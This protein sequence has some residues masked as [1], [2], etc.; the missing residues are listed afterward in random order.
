MTDGESFESMLAAVRSLS[1]DEIADAIETIGFACTDCGAC[2]RGDDTEEHT[3]TIFPDEIRHIAERT[4]TAWRD[5]ARPMPYG[6]D[7]DGTGET[8][9]WA[10]ATDECGDCRFL[11]A[12]E[13]G[14]SRCG[15]YQDRPLICR[16]YPFTLAASP[17]GEPL[18]E[19]VAREGPLV[20]HE[21]EGLGESIGRDDAE[22][23]ARALKRRGERAAREAI[24]VRDALAE[25]H[26]AA[27]TVVVDSEGAKMPDGTPLDGQAGQR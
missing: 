6:L 5:V 11:E 13:D 8:I 4:D 7:A 10:L 15:V 18:G 26:P 17:A 24:A 16:T 9:E 20:A 25:S 1:I 23:L 12:R 21:C 22:R 19:P 14:R 3:A 27:P 2:C